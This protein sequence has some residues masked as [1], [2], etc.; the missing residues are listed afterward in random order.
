[1][2]PDHIPGSW[3]PRSA[4][5][6][7]LALGKEQRTTGEQLSSQTEPW[8]EGYPQFRKFVWILWAQI[9]PFPAFSAFSICLRLVK[10]F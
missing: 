10:V 7:G 9:F 6:G 2:L 3:G 4:G 8:E 5:K 1:M